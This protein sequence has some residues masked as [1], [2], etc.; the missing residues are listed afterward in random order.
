L[1]GKY[2]LNYALTNY[3]AVDEFNLRKPTQTTWRPTI[4][5]ILE[6]NHQ[7]Q[8]FLNLRKGLA[9]RI[10]AEGFYASHAKHMVYSVGCDFR[11]Y[12]RLGKSVFA[13]VRT[14]AGTSGA[15]GKL[16]FVLGGM[17]NQLGADYE[18][19]VP[20]GLNASYEYQTHTTGLRGYKVGVRQGSSYVLMSGELRLP[21][22]KMLFKN[23]LRSVFLSDFQVVGFADAGTAWAGGSPFSD[24]NELYVRYI[25]NGPIA[26]KTYE[27]HQPIVASY[28]LGLRGLVLGYFMKI[29]YAWPLF[30]GKTHQAVIQ[31]AMGLDF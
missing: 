12:A 31:V 16:L 26:V 14:A 13:A 29:D 23:P 30:D 15:A 8:I 19:Q 10:F 21:V 25:N 11:Y 4:G 18:N 1:S 5:L 24:E 2:S 20:I 22:F 7:H 28:G 17:Y 27:Q 9:Y 6:N 3:K